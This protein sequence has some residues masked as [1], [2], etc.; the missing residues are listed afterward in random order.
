MT[1]L[2]IIKRSADFLAR[3]GVDSPRLQAEL[4][5]AHLLALPRMKLYLKFDRV[6][7][8]SEVAQY[9]DLIQRRG[10]REPLQ[11]IIGSTSFCGLEFAL[12]RHVLIPRPETELL[13]ERAW[14]FLQ[15]QC[16]PESELETQAGVALERI[17]PNRAENAFASANPGSSAT[18]TILP[19]PVYCP[20]VLDFGTGSGC[21]AI[22]LAVKNP[23]VAVYAVEICANATALAKQNS[24]RHQVSERIQFLEGDGFSVLPTALL[25]DL[26]I[27]NPPY[28]PTAE[29]AVLQ[30]EVRDFEPRQALDGGPD[31][32]E[33]FRRMASDAP[34]FLKSGGKLMLEFGDG[35]ADAINHIFQS[36][37]WIVDAL[38][39]DYTGRP[40]ILVAKRPD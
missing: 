6:L 26:I 35:Q 31:G 10:Q 24:Q 30:T 18:S 25:F 40:R 38:H 4:L 27:S 11:Y 34:A 16:A 22:T 33:Y 36:E 28:I 9:R 12:N 29:L 17:L 3:K 1:V 23:D 13:A 39:Q 8:T 15:S 32:L 2:E 37:K 21:L 20:N 14:E 5:L 19:R 7:T